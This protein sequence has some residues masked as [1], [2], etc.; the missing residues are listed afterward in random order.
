MKEIFEQAVREK[1]FDCAV[2]PVASIVFSPELLKACESNICGNYNKC[3]TCP[4]AI[5]S[6]EEQKKKI[7][8]FSSA[9]VFTTKADLEDSFDYDG[10]TRAKV[11]HDRLTTE[12]HERFGAGNAV[13]GAGG[14]TK[15]RPCA[16][17]A[18]CRFPG[19][20]YS[21]IEA[22]GINVTE[23]SRAAGIR[24]NN[25]ENTVTYFSMILYN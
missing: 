16:Y 11:F 3:W 19:K 24:Y 12:M 9:F 22:A 18:P 5:G 13:Y 14:C 1:A 6:L 25:G 7:S 2:I 4:P 15:C 10:M 8:S 21:S 23:L 17:P 20:T